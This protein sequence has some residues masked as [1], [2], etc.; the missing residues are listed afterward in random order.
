MGE[1]EDKSKP[2]HTRIVVDIPWMSMQDRVKKNLI[3]LNDKKN[4][5]LGGQGCNCWE[6]PGPVL[7]QHATSIDD[8]LQVRVHRS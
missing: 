2:K 3:E 7:A 8:P 4:Q 1:R 5:E 6:V